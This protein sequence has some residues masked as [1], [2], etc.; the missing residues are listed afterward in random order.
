[1]NNFLIYKYTS[2]SGKSYI[3]QTCRPKRRIIEHKR[4]LS[5]CTALS[6]AI[7]KYGYD[8]FIYEVIA[9]NLTI[10]E[11]NLLEEQ[12]IREHNTLSPNGYNLKFGGL[13]FKCSEETIQ[14]MSKS[15]KGVSFTDEHKQNIS[16]ALI[17]IS[18][19][20]E[21]K[22]NISLAH[23]GKRLTDEHKQNISK[24]HGGKGK[25]GPMTGKKHK[26]ESIEQRQAKRKGIKWKVNPVSGKREYYFPETD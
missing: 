18:H 10:E 19:S 12:F 20:E 21:R 1:M 2:P 7:Q 26:K 16:L 24:N 14:K 13:N 22:Q 17:G 5:E 6:R 11:A 8:N 25:P 23:T 9:E 3:G 15:K 4:M